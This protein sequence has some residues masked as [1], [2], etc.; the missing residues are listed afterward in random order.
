MGIECYRVQFPKGMDANEYALKVQPAAKSLGMLL[1]K[2]AWLGKGQRP[3]VTVI[4]PVIEPL[5]AIPEKIEP[6]ITAEAKPEAAAKESILEPAPETKQE[7]TTAGEVLPLAAE[8]VESSRRRRNALR[9][10]DYR[11]ARRDQAR[12]DRHHAGRPPL[13]RARPREEHELRTVAR[14]R[15]GSHEPGQSVSGTNPRGESGFHVDTLDLYPARQRTVFMKQARE[16]LGV[17]EEVIR[18]DLGHVLLKL[19]ELQDEQ[20]KTSAR[21]EGARNHAERG[22]K[23]R[24]A[25][26]LLRDPRLLDRILAD[27]ERCGMVGEETNKLVSYLARDL[28]PLGIAAGD[29]GAVEFRR[30][31]N[32]ADGSGAGVAARRAAGAVLGH[33]RPVALLH[34]R[35]RPEAQGAGHRGRRR[36]V[37]R[38]L[39]AET[40]AVGRRADHRSAPARTPPR[41]GSSRTSIASKGR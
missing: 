23:A 31:K 27:F 10:A 11:S 8:A 24:Q 26:D 20:I 3:A 19:E 38:S 5:R 25:L 22:R 17:K 9:R 40:V 33:D 13:S 15:A 18:R 12:G 36:R 6:A 34:G 21:T 29:P 35:D 1:N 32:G 30:R 4:E 14:Q 37:A 39:R 2:A 16:E 28:A 7:G 41:A